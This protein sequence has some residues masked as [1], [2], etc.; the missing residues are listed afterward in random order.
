LLKGLE[1]TNELVRAV[2]ARALD[3]AAQANATGVREG[4]ENGLK[5]PVRAVRVASAFS[6]RASL[7]T[8]S[9]TGRELLQYFAVNADEPAGQVQHGVFHF[10]RNELPAA[11]THFEKA[12]EWDPGS[13]AVQQELA[14]VYS[15]MNRPQDAVKA[16][17]HACQLAPKDP[18]SH[19]KLGLALNEVGD[20]KGTMQELKAVVELEPRHSGA[21]YNLG[22]AQSAAGEEET[23]LFSLSRAETV[24][25]LDQRIPYARATILARLG[26]TQEARQAAG[27]V[28]ELAPGNAE[29]RQLWEMLGR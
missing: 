26:R 1:H 13:A 28:L 23:A 8:N 14:V 17:K 11:L 20:P 6:L 5:D 27:R 3:P 29:A 2:A 16:L 12:A 21:W 24:S 25:P 22:L 19:Y 7:S 10:S 18:E 15:A 9:V 4:L